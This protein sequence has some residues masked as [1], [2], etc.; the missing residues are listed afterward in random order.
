MVAVATAM[1]TKAF[2]IGKLPELLAKVVHQPVPARGAPERGRE[3][4]EWTA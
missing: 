3:E 1:A 2:R 4:E